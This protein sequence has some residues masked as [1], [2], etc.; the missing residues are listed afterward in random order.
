MKAET[1]AKISEEVDELSKMTI[2]EL[3]DQ[4]ESH[5][6]DLQQHRTTFKLVQQQLKAAERK[7]NVVKKRLYFVEKFDKLQ[8]NFASALFSAAGNDRK[9][10]R[11]RSVFRK[12][13]LRV[14]KEFAEFESELAAEESDEEDKQASRDGIQEKLDNLAEMFA[15]LVQQAEVVAED[16]ETNATPVVKPE[17]VDEEEVKTPPKTVE[18]APGLLI[19]V[20]SDAQ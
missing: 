2:R 20:H 9:E 11:A 6:E 1:L 17:V 5:G 12:K 19:E 10:V 13:A 4:C 16:L 14:V 18:L 15:G 8:N 7:F 3:V